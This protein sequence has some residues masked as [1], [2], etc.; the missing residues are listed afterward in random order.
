M[1]RLFQENIKY[2]KHILNMNLLYHLVV[3]H[4]AK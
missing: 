4:T 1:Y 2:L 3:V